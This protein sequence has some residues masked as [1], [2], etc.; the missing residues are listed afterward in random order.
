MYRAVSTNGI[1][2]IYQ[3]EQE[4]KTPAGRDRIGQ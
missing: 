3:D 2:R 1:Y 4:L